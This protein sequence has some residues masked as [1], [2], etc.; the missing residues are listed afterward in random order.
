MAPV[1]V[2][3]E[4]L[5][6]DAPQEEISSQNPS[7]NDVRILLEPK[8]VCWLGR[9][10]LC[11]HRGLRAC[12]LSCSGLIVSELLQVEGEWRSAGVAGSL[13]IRLSCRCS[14]L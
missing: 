13:H 4:H 7:E 11:L 5:R 8:E 1:V 9:L 12:R 6:T 3:E 14:C 10:P 2:Q